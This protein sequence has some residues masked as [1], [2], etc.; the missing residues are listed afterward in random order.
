M[1]AY[2][3]ST[4]FLT[5]EVM[6]NKDKAIE[7]FQYIK[8]LYA[9]KSKIV[10]DIKDQIWF[11]YI[12][13]IPD[14]KENIAFNYF[15]KTAEDDSE[16]DQT[17]ILRIQKPE[18]EK[19]PDLPKELESWIDIGWDNFKFELKKIEKKATVPP[20]E[21]YIYFDDDAKRTAV[22][23]QW[24][25]IRKDWAIRQSKLA[26]TRD[27]FNR[28]YFLYIDLEREEENTEL[29][30]G[31]GIL[32]CLTDSGI[33]INHPI[34]LKRVKIEFDAQENVLTIVDSTADAEIYAIG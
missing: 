13:E 20:S 5:E 12:N 18:F 3:F 11:Q 16:L 25:K 31:Q 10:T 23:A 19:C 27:F 6:E 15:D 7:L 14:D 4:E 32:H 2:K 21:E 9:I 1:L 30:I 26:K 34:L 8:E 33:Q 28:L 29:M 22:F 24:S 17:F